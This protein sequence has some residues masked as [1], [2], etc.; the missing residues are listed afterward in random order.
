MLREKICHAKVKEN[1]EE[2]L[3]ELKKERQESAQRYTCKS[4][5]RQYATVKIMVDKYRRTTGKQKC[6]YNPL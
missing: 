3:T 6:E 5:R 2:K 4:I 1:F